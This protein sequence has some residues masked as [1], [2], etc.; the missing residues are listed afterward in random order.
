MS[1]GWMVYL[2]RY[3]ML[4]LTGLGMKIRVAYLVQNR[5]KVAHLWPKV[6]QNGH[7]S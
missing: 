3:V 6:A 2:Q 4:W 1:L 7:S 5:P